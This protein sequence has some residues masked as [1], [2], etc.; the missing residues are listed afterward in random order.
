MIDS[1]LV[2]LVTEPVYSVRAGKLTPVNWAAQRMGDL[3]TGT[4]RGLAGAI[5]QIAMIDGLIAYRIT[6][7]GGAVRIIEASRHD[8]GL[9]VKVLGRGATNDYLALRDNL[10]AMLNEEFHDPLTRLVEGI[11]EVRTKA[12]SDPEM[13][14]LVNNWLRDSRNLTKLTPVLMDLAKL[15]GHEAF[16]NEERVL[17][18]DV[19]PKIVQECRTPDLKQREVKILLQVDKNKPLGAMY[20]PAYWVEMALRCMLSDVV[21]HAAEKTTVRI[22]AR[23]M[24]YMLNLVFRVQ[25]QLGKNAIDPKTIN[26]RSL[27]PVDGE[28]TLDRAQ[29]NLAYAVIKRVGGN[30]RYQ[31]SALGIEYIVEI[32][33]GQGGGKSAETMAKS[34]SE[35]AEQYAKDI[36]MLMEAVTKRKK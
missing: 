17:F 35:Q 20:G 11:T 22:M 32:P 14:D 27:I 25:G 8:E 7:G 4:W 3:D 1:T 12:A 29:L 2:N 26:D 18:S 31:A 5:E 16:D 23:Q 13:F 30:L 9:V 15:Y 36:A 19:L 33:T 34:A 24:P 6:N 10:F 21:K 28:V